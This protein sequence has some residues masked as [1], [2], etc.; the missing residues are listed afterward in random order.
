[1]LKRL[2]NEGTIFG[3]TRDNGYKISRKS[4]DTSQKDRRKRI[5]RQWREMAGN[6]D[7]I[8][9]TVSP[10]KP[11]RGSSYVTARITRDKPEILEEM[12]ENCLK[13]GNAY[14]M[15]DKLIFF[16]IIHKTHNSIIMLWQ[17]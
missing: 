17:R 16:F 15:F 14:L 5:S 13:L 11:K 10:T 6:S 8:P 3:F 12:K 9:T 7:S 2:V 1:L 4:L